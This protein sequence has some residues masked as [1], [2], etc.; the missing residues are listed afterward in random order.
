MSGKKNS[1]KWQ[2]RVGHLHHLEIFVS[3][4]TQTEPLWRY[5]LGELGYRVLETWD[6]G[7]SFKKGPTF[8]AFV[9]V[10]EKH[11]DPPYH[12]KRVGM[13]HLA[14]YGES[15]AQ[16]DRLTEGVKSMGMRVL[17][18]DRHPHAGGENSYA[19][20][21]EDPDRIKVELIAPR[22]RSSSDG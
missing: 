20:F 4:I 16:V 18:E 21:F 12:R 14:F 3:D 6:G 13:N 9:Q 11:R 1:D 17:Y 22:E 5:F 19:L 2:S 10:Q 7:L 8:I 15:K